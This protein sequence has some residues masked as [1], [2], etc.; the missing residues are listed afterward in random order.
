MKRSLMK[1]FK[2]YFCIFLKIVSREDQ[3]TFFDTTITQYRRTPEKNFYQNTG[4]LTL[5]IY[6]RL[7]S[8]FINIADRL[9]EKKASTNFFCFFSVTKSV[10]IWSAVSVGFKNYT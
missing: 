9:P 5:D 10:L 6:D 4:L 1:F 2:S 3:S 8:A 7:N